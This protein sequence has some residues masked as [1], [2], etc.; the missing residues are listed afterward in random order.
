MQ[1]SSIIA[2]LG[3]L[4]VPAASVQAESPFV[5]A[6]EKQAVKKAREREQRAQEKKNLPPRAERPR[7]DEDRGKKRD[8]DRDNRPR[9]VIVER[10]VYVPAY[11][12]YDPFYGSYGYSPYGYGSYGIGRYDEAD[13]REDALLEAVAK[14]MR[15][16]LR[17][18]ESLKPFKLDT[19]TVGDSVEIEGTVDTVEQL[20]LALDVARGID[21][22]TRIVLTRLK[23]RKK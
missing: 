17:E 1:K 5:V 8:R 19:D 14:Q 21:P 9:T 22:R 7:R 16:A 3:V 20:Q 12:S 10:P 23:I 6:R 4:M 15:L 2:I 11:P 13:N 18:N